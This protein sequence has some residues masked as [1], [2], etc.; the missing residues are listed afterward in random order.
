VLRTLGALIPVTDACAGSG[1]GAAATARA[2][3]ELPLE[4][5]SHSAGV[6]RLDLGE[7]LLAQGLD[8]RVGC[9]LPGFRV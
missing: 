4:L 9:H 3:P 5:P 8:V 6:R 1:A 2:A 7:T